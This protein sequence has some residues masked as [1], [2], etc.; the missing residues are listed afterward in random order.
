MSVTPSEKMCFLHHFDIMNKR[1]HTTDIDSFLFRKKL[2]ISI[3]GRYAE[4]NQNIFTEKSIY[5]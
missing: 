5:V 2:D 4:Q 1:D 3:S